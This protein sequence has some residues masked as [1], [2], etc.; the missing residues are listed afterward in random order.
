MKLFKF[1]FEVPERVLIV[2]LCGLS[3]AFAAPTQ[4]VDFD[5]PAMEAS[6]AIP[7][8]ARQAG[9]QIVAP[10]DRLRGVQTA[11]LKGTYGHSQGTQAVADRNRAGNGVR[12]RHDHHPE[13]SS[14]GRSRGHRIAHRARA[15][16]GDLSAGPVV[17]T[18]GHGTQRSNDDSGLFEYL[19][20]RIHQQRRG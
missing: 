18:C 17:L 9:L 3:A 5:V 6:S 11:A 16:S 14:S 12:R 1:N 20:Q 13:I 4:E 7:E 19:A 10:A 2:F 8:F 15:G